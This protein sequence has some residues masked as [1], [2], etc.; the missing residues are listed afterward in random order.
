[1][2]PPMLKQTDLKRVVSCLRR[3]NGIMVD[4]ARLAGL[5]EN[6]FKY[7]LRQ[8][9]AAGLMTNEKATNN[10]NSGRSK[11]QLDALD[12]LKREVSIL[13]EQLAARAKIPRPVKLKARKGKD[14]IRLIIPDTHS[15]HI[16]Q[17]AFAALLADAQAIDPDEIIGLGDHLDCGGFLAQHHTIGYLGQ[18]DESA[19]AD[20]LTTWEDQLNR[21]TAAAPRAKW[22]LLEGNHEKRVEQWAVTQTLGN[23]RDAMLLMQALCPEYRLKYKERGIAYVKYGEFHPGHTVRGA[24]QLG[25]CW[26]TH[27][28]ACGPNAA[29][30]TAEKFGAPVVYGHTHTPATYFGKTVHNGVHA[31]W[32][33]GTLGNF[34]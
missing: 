12:N 9:V 24:I 17:S 31:A 30:K 23:K 29:K 20:D 1:M 13:R 4:G 34:V 14:V 33:F 19:Y 6:T 8:A 28:S 7:R 26:F 16:D 2:A 15:Q 27:G 5:R 18:L 32:N 21:L 22:W 10:T 11:N 25:R 3:A